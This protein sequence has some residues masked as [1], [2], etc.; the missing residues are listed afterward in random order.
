M[1]EELRSARRNMISQQIISRGVRDPHVLDALLAVP[2]H[3]FVPP[4]NRMHAYDDGALTIGHGQTISQP[5]MVAI[6]SEALRVEP[7]HRV[8]EIGTGSGYQT[9]VLA[10]IAAQVFTIERHADLAEDARMLLEELGYSNIRFRQGDGSLGWPEDAPFDRIVVT[11]GA[12]AVPEDLT[13]QLSDGGLLVIPVGGRSVQELYR[14]TRRRGEMEGER[15]TSCR[16][17]PL[18]GEEGWSEA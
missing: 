10:E 4:T 15:I 16:F 3:I 9:A 7:H 17:V 18:V 8:L 2:R 14:Y 6:M 12:P 5:Y 11:A 1:S 13:A